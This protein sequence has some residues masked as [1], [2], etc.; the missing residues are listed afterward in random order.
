M[1][2]WSP[3]TLALTLISVVSWSLFDTSRKKLTDG[4]GALQLSVFL[5]L[6]QTPFFLIWAWSEGKAVP[7]VSYLSPA[8]LGVLTN[9]AA[10]V[11]FLRALTLSPMSKTIPILA[12][13]P[14]LASLLG[15]L[16]LG[17]IPTLAAGLGMIFIV[18]GSFLL[19]ATPNDLKH[20][21]NLLASF[22]RE[23]GC[24]YMLAV[25]AFWATASMCDKMALRHASVAQHALFQVVGVVVLLGGIA[26]WRGGLWQGTPQ[27]VR[28]PAFWASLLFA[29]SALTFQLEAIQL[30]HVGLF[31]AVKRSLG[32]VLSALFGVLFFREKL[33]GLHSLALVVMALGSVLLFL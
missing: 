8:A 12:F 7:P 18:M 9:A 25:A 23:P 14:M 22:T 28:R 30:V 26:L 15:W 6:S 32:I 21:M 29:T 11:C 20:P 17:E 33:T 13:A 5:T 19:N 27:L 1:T 4:F 24:A 2:P 16:L 3:L 10:S 31:E